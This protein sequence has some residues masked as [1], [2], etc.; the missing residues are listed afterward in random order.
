MLI[1]YGYDIAFEFDFDTP[2]L[3]MLDVHPSRRADIVVPDRAI[4]MPNVRARP[5]RDCFGNLCRRMVAPKGELALSAEGVIRD[6][7]VT[8]PVVPDATQV[9]ID[10]LPNEA[11]VFL[12]GSRYC[13]TDKLSQ[14]AWQTFGKVPA[15][16]TRVQAIVDFVHRHLTFDYLKA[17]ATRSA[18][19]AF[20]DG[21]GVC[22]DFAHLSIALC[23]A[24]SIP[25]RYCTG[26]L[27]D[28][29][30]PKDPAPM[31]FSAWFEVYLAGRWYAFD[32]RHNRPRI[33]RI[34]IGIGRDA[35]DVAI[36]NA[37]ALHRLTRFEVVTEEISAEDV[38]QMDRSAVTGQMLAN[39][40]GDRSVHPEFGRSDLAS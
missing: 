10:K 4:S 18:N 23:R 15:G 22:R 25:A 12:L 1:R 24:M 9:A 26:Y 28:I 39:R 36:L 11:L 16:W 27:G 17:S 21:V 29:G 33:G 30:V 13:E 20:A 3:T 6:R 35:A 8:E 19:E 31:D 32:A 14:F 37:F 34:L 7:G 2:I 38:A 40:P 5:Y